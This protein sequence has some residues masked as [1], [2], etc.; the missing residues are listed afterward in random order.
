MEIA[1]GLIELK[2]GAEQSVATW[3]DTLASRRDEVMQ[4][5]RNEG[6]ET[7]S[8]FEVEISGKRFLLWYMR[9]QSMDKALETFKN[10]T[11][12]IDIFHRETLGSVAREAILASP[13]LDFYVENSKD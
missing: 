12:D 11:N 10:S 6:V 1:A 3:R 4:S 9:T 7:E 5:L 13:L 2:D 8:W